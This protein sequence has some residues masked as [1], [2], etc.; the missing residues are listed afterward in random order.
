M[1]ASSCFLAAV[2][3]AVNI[4]TNINDAVEDWQ[5]LEINSRNRLPARTYSMPLKDAS[6][7]MTSALEPETPYKKTLNGKWKISWCG[8][9]KLR[10]LDFWK[11]SFDDSEWELID[12][13]SC[14]ELKGFGS[15]G[16]V[17]IRYPHKMQWPKILDRASGKNDYNPVSS[18]RTHFSVPN[19][20][21]GRDVILRFDGVYSAYYV[22]VNGQMVGYA[23]DSKLPSEFDITKFLISGK[24]NL[25]AVEVYR[26][27][28]GSYLEDQDMFRFSGIFRDV[29]IWA[30]PKDGIWDFN[31]KTSLSADYKTGSISVEGIDGAWTGELKDAKGSLV[32]SFDSSKDTPGK[33]KSI[34]NIN[35]WSAETPYLYTLILK[36]GD[37]IRMKRIGF[38]EQKIVGNAFLVNGKKIKLKGVNRHECSPTGGRTVQLKDML[39][40]V[41]LMKRYN[42]NTVR[43]SHYPNHYLWYDI[44]DMYGI[45]LVAEANVEAHEYGYGEKSL[46]LF[47]EW[48]H[49]IVERNMRNVVFYRNNPSIVMWSMGNETGHGDCF[50]NALAETKRLDPSRPRHWERGNTDADIDSTMYPA[51]EWLEQRGR[52]GDGLAPATTDDFN[53]K[54]GNLQTPGKAFFLCEYAHAM[55]NAIGNLSEYWDVFYKYDSLVGGCIWDWIDQAVYKKA[56]RLTDDG[57][58]VTYLAYGGDF[59]E[60][61]NDGPFCC[62]GVIRPD[63]SVSAKLIEVAHVYRNLIVRAKGEGA[64]DGLEIENRFGFTDANEFDGKWELLSDG[65]VVSSG[66]F[67]PPSVKPLSRAQLSLP[68]MDIPAGKECFL[69][70]YFSLKN[71]TLWANKGWVVASSQIA[72]SKGSTNEVKSAAD[73]MQIKVWSN[74]NSISIAAGKSQATFSRRTGTLSRLVMN[75]V[76][77]LEDVDGMVAGPKLGVMR[78]LTDNDVWLRRTY[79]YDKFASSLYESG[80]T[81]LTYHAKPLKVKRN[82][83]GSVELQSNVRVNGRKSAGFDYA[84]KW[85]F[86]PDGTL[87]IDCSTVPFGTQPFVVPRFGTEWKI[88][89]NLSHVQWY[90]RGPYENYIDRKSGSLIGI[91][92][93]TVSEMFEPYVRPQ[94][95]SYR[96]DVRWVRFKDSKGR[97][98]QFSFQNPMFV[99]AMN[100]DREDLDGARHISGSRR[101]LN[102]KA[103]RKE[104]CLNI[105]L[106]Q[107]GLGGGSCG[108][109]PLKKYMFEIKPETWS[110]EISPIM[111]K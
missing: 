33:P 29:S 74:K 48:N 77:I 109:G 5:N 60:E 80:L 83:D 28:D 93:S 19:N 31:V 106:H 38:K 22:W 92:S 65:E 85:L 89:G 63:R 6:S 42:I 95:C 16:Y 98:I 87:R 104:I 21:N 70:V 40:D 39:D 1:I 15:P 12:V 111:P 76:K 35:L 45:Y 20:W 4:S 53:V 94:D 82:D 25:L 99:Q 69:N 62:N 37:D 96:S 30:K 88:N 90:G 52:A 66:T 75:G 86:R 41:K 27:C 72:L 47:K 3:L 73:R 44:C 56:D 57:Q 23:E 71:D 14:V 59:D 61:P 11:V 24:E 36:K 81:Q 78:A 34:S 10:P 108:P 84:T 110:M 67:A 51:V 26:W 91:Y 43:T 105:D 68:K 100:Y 46:G 101:I 58:R 9:P 50:R 55:G 54:T 13:P 17:N 7:A 2:F 64:C 8:D 79:R 102:F 107:L 103:P 97:G 18:Y 32:T 49:S